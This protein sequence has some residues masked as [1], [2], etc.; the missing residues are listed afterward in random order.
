MNEQL[1][2]FTPPQEPTSKQHIAILSHLRQGLT[3]TALDALRI[4]GSMKLASRIGELKKMGWDIK[5]EIIQTETGKH[6]SRYW[7]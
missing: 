7:L 6:V 4:A 1:K 3:M 5:S 2:L